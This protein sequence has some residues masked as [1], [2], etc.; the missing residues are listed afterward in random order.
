MQILHPEI[1]MENKISGTTCKGVG[2]YYKYLGAITVY[3][4]LRFAYVNST[5]LKSWIN[6]QE[7]SVSIRFQF[8]GLGF[9]EM[10]IKYLPR[11]LYKK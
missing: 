2:Q 7:Q 1:F 5:V 6:E 8:A 9:L 11:Q 10:A 4:H 3:G